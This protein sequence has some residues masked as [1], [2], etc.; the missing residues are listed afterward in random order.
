MLGLIMS[1]VDNVRFLNK[2][3]VLQCVIS[4]SDFQLNLILGRMKFSR[5]E[6]TLYLKDSI[7]NIFH[8]LAALLAVRN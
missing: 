6:I 2:M 3:T 1:D 5:P 7:Q 4:N 8:S